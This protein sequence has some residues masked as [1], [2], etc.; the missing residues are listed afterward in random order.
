MWWHF[1]HLKNA[2]MLHSWRPSNLTMYRHCDGS[3]KQ[4][5]FWWFIE[6]WGPNLTTHRRRDDTNKLLK[7]AICGAANFTIEK[8]ACSQKSIKDFWWNKHHSNPASQKQTC[9]WRPSKFKELWSFS[10][11][12]CIV[13]LI[14]E[15]LII[16]SLL[17][18]R[19]ARGLI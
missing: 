9:F 11:G 6:F 14:R 19:L 17:F 5:Y 12:W 8:F 13:F 7:I 3:Q 10:V 15:Y 16:T 4:V 1:E 18:L 2:W